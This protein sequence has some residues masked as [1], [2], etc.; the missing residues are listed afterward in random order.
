MPLGIV[1]GI[2]P[3][4]EPPHLLRIL[5]RC[6]VGGRSWGWLRFAGDIVGRDGITLRHQLRVVVANEMAVGVIF[7]AGFEGRGRL[8]VG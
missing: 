1:V 7:V 5:G 6:G 8:W 3:T 4:R 2:H